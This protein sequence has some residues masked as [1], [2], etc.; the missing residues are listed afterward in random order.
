MKQCLRI[1][2]FTLIFGV[3]SVSPI[4]ADPAAVQAWPSAAT[5]WVNGREIPFQAYEID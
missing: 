1:A 3:L 4:A 2:L 5:V